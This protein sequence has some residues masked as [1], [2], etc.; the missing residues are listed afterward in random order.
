VNDVFACQEEFED[1]YVCDP[2][3]TDQQLD[4]CIEAAEILEC[5]TAVPFV[6]FD[7]LCNR[8][9]GCIETPTTPYDTDTDTDTDTQTDTD[10]DTTP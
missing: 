10:T 9:V 1:S 5:P 6:C 2:E 8:E 7:V 4:L 3:A